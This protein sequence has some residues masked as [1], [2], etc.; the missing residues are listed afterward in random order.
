MGPQNCY[1]PA[2]V[3]HDT[4][5]LVMID[6]DFAFFYISSQIDR[7]LKLLHIQ[8]QNI[9]L[10]LKIFQYAKG[11]LLT[12]LFSDNFLPNRGWFVD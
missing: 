2:F 5:Q 4:A 1:L 7:G 3:K 11:H 12:I 10:E 6:L 8:Q 9:V